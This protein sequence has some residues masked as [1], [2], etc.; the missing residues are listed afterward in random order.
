MLESRVTLAGAK[1]ARLGHNGEV[2]KLLGTKRNTVSKWAQKEL[3]DP[4]VVFSQSSG[5][6][7]PL[8]LPDANSQNIVLVAVASR[9]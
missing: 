2:A 6:G 9:K 1:L 5:H 8:K 7:A 3:S 4:D